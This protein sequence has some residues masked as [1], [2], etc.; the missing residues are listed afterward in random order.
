MGNGYR[1]TVQRVVASLLIGFATVFSFAHAQQTPATPAS[2][3]SE[4]ASSKN[5]LNFIAV[6]DWGRY[7]EPAQRA[8]ATQMARTAEK[9]DAQFFISTGDNF[10]PNG[11]A[12]VDD[13][14]WQQSYELVYTDFVLHNDWYVVLGNHDYRGNPQAEV[15]Y[16]KRSE[17][18]HMPSRYY[19]VTKKIDATTSA[20]FFFID[21][22]PFIADYRK[23]LDKYAVDGQDTQAQLRWLEAELAKSKAKWKFVVGHHHVYS[24]G[25]RSTQIELEQ[26]IVPL[27]KKYGV[28]VYLCGHE[29]DLQVIQRPGGKITYLVS[30]AGAEHRPTGKTDGTLFSLSAFGFMALSLKADQLKV[31]VVDDTGATRYETTVQP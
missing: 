19:S 24:G 26:A 7:G 23:N 14:Q 1:K 2:G 15:D 9:V 29:H 5:V 12:S 8:V 6:G 11:V 27:M 18:W 20:Q 16:T 22:S 28:Q 4:A 31:Q 13:P 25:K 10:Y 30:G 17:R 3:E 21:T